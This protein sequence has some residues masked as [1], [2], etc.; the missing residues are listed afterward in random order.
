M[1][2]HEVIVC[3]FVVKTVQFGI[4]FPC[5]VKYLV[6]Q[7]LQCCNG[8]VLGLTLYC[9]CRLLSAFFVRASKP[10]LSFIRAVPWKAMWTGCCSA[11]LILV[12]LCISTRPLTG[13]FG[14]KVRQSAGG[15]KT[16]LSFMATVMKYD[17]MALAT[18]VTVVFG[19]LPHL[20]HSKRDNITC[21]DGT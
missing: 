17:F 6:C 12:A 21:R 4:H 18:I 8:L 5:K 1:V 2:G 9:S 20:F 7:H 11:E 13:S 3:L 10:G 16:N 15:S 14:R 19:G